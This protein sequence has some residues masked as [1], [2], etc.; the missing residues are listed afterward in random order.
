MANKE[1]S[2]VVVI[3][4]INITLVFIGVFGAKWFGSRIVS[5]TTA[6]VGIVTFLGL[7]AALFSPGLLIERTMRHAIA[8]STIAMY[9]SIV[10]MTTFFPETAADTSQTL[11]PLTETMIKSFQTVI[12]VVIGFYF[13][14]SAVVEG[15]Q[16]FKTGKAKDE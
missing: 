2:A 13:T 16:R 8:G 9:L 11:R 5:F 12:S 10:G 14:S 6:S 3:L 7:F 1:R 4:L 15:I